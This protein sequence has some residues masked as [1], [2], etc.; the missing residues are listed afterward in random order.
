[1][2]STST[3]RHTTMTRHLQARWALA[4]NLLGGRFDVL[5]SFGYACTDG[6]ILILAFIFDGITGCC[7]AF[8][9]RIYD[10]WHR[11]CA[12]VRSRWNLHL[13]RCNAAKASVTTCWSIVRNAAVGDWSATTAFMA[14]YL[15][16][17]ETFY[18]SPTTAY[19]LIFGLGVY[20]PH[21]IFSHCAN[22]STN[23]VKF[24]CCTVFA[25]ALY[26]IVQHSD[27]DILSLPE[28]VHPRD[29][30]LF[31]QEVNSPSDS[32]ILPTWVRHP[33]ILS[34][35]VLTIGCVLGLAFHAVCKAITRGFTRAVASTRPYWARLE[36]YATNRWTELRLWATRV[37][38][39]PRPQAAIRTIRERLA[40]HAPTLTGLDIFGFSF[41]VWS[42]NRD[43][44][45]ILSTLIRSAI[46]YDFSLLSLVFK[47][48]R[49][50]TCVCIWSAHQL[51][52][53]HRGLESVS[54]DGKQGAWIARADWLEGCM[55]SLLIAGTIYAA[56]YLCRIMWNDKVGGSVGDANGARSRPAVTS[57]NNINRS[58]LF[59]HPE[60]ELNV[61]MTVDA[62]DHTVSLDEPIVDKPGTPRVESSAMHL[63]NL[64]DEQMVSENGGCAESVINLSAGLPTSTPEAPPTPVTPD[65]DSPTQTSPSHLS[66][67]ATH[68]SPTPVLAPSETSITPSA[69]L[70]PQTAEASTTV[71]PDS[72]SPR[73]FCAASWASTPTQT[74]VSSLDNEVTDHSP[75]PT[76]AP[77]ETSITLL[78]GPSI[79]T[80]ESHTTPLPPLP[81]SPQPPHPTSQASPPP[82]QTVL[83][84]DNTATPSSPT[85]LLVP[86]E[87]PSNTVAADWAASL[88][89][90]AVMQ[91]RDGRWAE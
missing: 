71:A 36:P 9:Q 4:V 89:P 21:L 46:D 80:P 83:N 81:P 2:N 56:L 30:L 8:A 32:L 73:S 25:A 47:C 44:A 66:N 12:F 55:C 62:G 74:D 31:G 17:R 57:F 82:P 27:Y 38:H 19:G 87:K 77:S 33:L 52:D 20:L 58:D 61:E 88:N 60:E 70:P 48:I 42:S 37:R 79:P 43:F 7:G 11:L 6:F 76:L 65:S 68:R 23:V 49:F 90:H 67:K 14:R 63:P 75:T 72:S 39:S 10:V 84:L 22:A 26:V 85:P 45:N 40:T 18:L 41:L 64:P 51:V 86:I 69:A 5:R 91:A 78:S 13:N 54:L 24:V 3:N 53:L 35:G 1:M 50:A 34:T 28:T 15:P 16:T 59:S 29:S